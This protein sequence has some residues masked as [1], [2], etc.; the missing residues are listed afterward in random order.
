MAGR[1]AALVSSYEAGLKDEAVV[2]AATIPVE[3]I[4][5]PVLLLSGADDQMWP[6]ARMGEMVMRRLDEHGFGFRHEHLIYEGVGHSI[7]FPY[8]PTTMGNMGTLL[9]GGTPEGTAAAN[10][11]SWPKVLEFLEEGL[12]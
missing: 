5:G 11:D 2:A 10:A 9:E 12:R 8:V 4:G 6:S 7:G 1:P 3:N